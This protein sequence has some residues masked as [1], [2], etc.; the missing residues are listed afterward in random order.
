MSLVITQYTYMLVECC[1]SQVLNN[2]LL[3][4]NDRMTLVLLCHMQQLHFW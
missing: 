2:M 3:Y 4:T 1:I